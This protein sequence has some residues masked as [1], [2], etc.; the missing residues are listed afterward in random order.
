[1]IAGNANLQKNLQKVWLVCNVK[2]FREIHLSFLYGTKMNILV[3]D[4][5]P[6]RT[7]KNS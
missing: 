1:M 5:F 7:I 4:L 3:D 2:K 6:F